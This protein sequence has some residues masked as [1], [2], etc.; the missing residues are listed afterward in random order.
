MS[1][2]MTPSNDTSQASTFVK[3]NIDK[4]LSL[5]TKISDFDKNNTHSDTIVNI[6]QSTID[7]SNVFIADM[8][9]V[10]NVYS[11]INNI[12]PSSAVDTSQNTTTYCNVTQIRMAEDLLNKMNNKVFKDLLSGQILKILTPNFKVQMS[13]MSK[14]SYSDYAIIDEEDENNSRVRI[15]Q[16]SVNTTNYCDPRASMCLNKSSIANLLNSSNSKNIAFNFKYNKNNIIAINQSNLSYAY[17]KDSLNYSILVGDQKGKYRLLQSSPSQN[18]VTKLRMPNLNNSTTISSTTCIQYDSNGS[19]KDS[20]CTSWYDY[21]N[22]EVLCICQ[23]YGLTVNCY[24]KTQSDLKKL[25]Q[26]GDPST[27]FSK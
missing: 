25:A 12:L 13:K 8:K 26:F 3:T 6:L 14:V 24:D 5:M 23:D 4:I 10:T 7:N 18:F 9:K 27:L 2:V 1:S 19:P 17:S 11:I 22:M 21:K 16:S 15:L 20:N